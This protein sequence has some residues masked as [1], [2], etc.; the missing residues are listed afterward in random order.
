[1]TVTD[2]ILDHFDPVLYDVRDHQ[3]TWSCRD[4]A[5][6]RLLSRSSTLDVRA[7]QPKPDGLLTA[8]TRETQDVFAIEVTEPTS[9]DRARVPDVWALLAI[10]TPSVIYDST[11]TTGTLA[12]QAAHRR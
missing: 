12:G 8:Y 4:E 10:P 3:A 7:E 9:R 5:P 1:M 6:S 11:P 2:P